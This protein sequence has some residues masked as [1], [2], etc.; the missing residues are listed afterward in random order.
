MNR[1]LPFRKEKRGFAGKLQRLFPVLSLRS[2]L[3][4]RLVIGSRH[5]V[6]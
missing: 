1:S 6:K 2:M 4:V 5:A 3:D